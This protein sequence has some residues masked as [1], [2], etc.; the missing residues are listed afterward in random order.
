MTTVVEFLKTPAPTAPS[1][2]LLPGS[3]LAAL[4]LGATRGSEEVLLAGAGL[5]ER[6]GAKLHVLHAFEFGHPAY[7]DAMVR[8]PTFESR[9]RSARETLR[10]R[11]AAALPHG[12]PVSSA[13]VVIDVAHRALAA[14]AREVEANV[15]VLGPHRG[16]L[17]HGRIVG[18][19][20]NHAI[21]ASGLPCWIARGEMRLP[22]ERI[23]VATDFSETARTALDL[24]LAWIPLLGIDRNRGERGATEVVLT[25]HVWR[26]VAREAP[27]F[28]STFVRPHLELEEERVGGVAESAGTRLRTVVLHGEEPGRDLQ[29]YAVRQKAGLIVVGTGGHGML[30]RLMLGSFAASVV[31]Q[32][33]LP[34][35]TVPPKAAV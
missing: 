32:S 29:R 9:L 6:A 34:V 15:L 18:T 7:P 10:D 22:L 4:D 11:V 2:P 1:P 27:V 17:V 12:V 26:G 21:R 3:I 25:H 8:W 23:I 35:L 20:A 13:A 30:H 31:G 14:R 33:R 16:R 28:E 19:T 24:V 5:A